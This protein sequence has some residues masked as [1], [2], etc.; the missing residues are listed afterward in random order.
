MKRLLQKFLAFFRWY[1]SKWYIPILFFIVWMA[2]IMLSVPAIFAEST[3]V[4]VILTVY[5]ILWEVL[6]LS[7]GVYLSSHGHSGRAA[8]FLFMFLI[9]TIILVL[10][11]LGPQGGGHAFEA[12]VQ[13]QVDSFEENAEA[14]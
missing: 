7:L 2:M 3:S 12:P 10:P 8:F 6:T 13:E 5:I 14:L 4:C 11:V 1:S 9:G